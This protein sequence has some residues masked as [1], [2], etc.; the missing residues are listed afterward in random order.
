MSLNLYPHLKDLGKG[1]FGIT[2]LA[3][4]TLLPTRPKCVVKKLIPT[5]NDPRL[6]QLLQDRFK[7]EAI[8]LEN[9]SKGS[10]G[11]IPTLYH[12]F[13]EQ[14]EFYLVQE[15][16]DGQTLTDKVSNQGRFSENQVRQILNDLLVT[17]S[18]VHQKGII[19]RD[20]KPDNIMVRYSDDKPVL[21]DFGAVKEIMSTVMSGSENTGRS[22]VIGTPGFMPVEQ[23]SGR[24]MFASDIYALGMTAIYLLTGRMPQEIETDPDTGNIKWQIYAPNVS[25][26][27][28]EVLNKSIQPVPNY[29]YNNAQTMLQDLNGAVATQAP[30]GQNQTV[31]TTAVAPVPRGY[32]EQVYTPPAKQSQEQYSSNHQAVNNPQINPMILAMAGV[33]VGGGLIAG[34][35]VLGSNLRK[36]SSTNPPPKDNIIIS[37]P[38][39][40]NQSSPTPIPI[41]SPSPTPTPTPSPIDNPSTISR[42]AAVNTIQQW[43]QYKRTLFAPPYDKQPSADLLTGKAYRNNINRSGDPCNS[44]DPDDCLSSVDWL[45]RYDAQYSFGVQR[46]D[47]IDKFEASGDSGSIFVTVTEYRTLHKTGGRKTSSGGTSQVRY[48]LQFDNGK[49]KI[50]DYK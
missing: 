14:S 26:K 47:T 15:Y 43:L 38:N 8:T 19:H 39:N 33:L 1:G 28:L 5:S 35:L 24:P 44:S 2:Y 9:L 21:I 23:M 22:I 48:D 37:A 31:A 17:L 10:N 20:I 29:R 6:Q 36:D 34:G 45:Q 41:P 3:T 7:Q 11:K 16:I 46:I 25:Q 18:Y 42:E 49:V 40:N 30:I 4:N 13:V 12:Y 50:S 27:L 32:Q